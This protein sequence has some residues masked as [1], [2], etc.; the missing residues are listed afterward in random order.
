MNY[1]TN[2]SRIHTFLKCTWNSLQVSVL[3]HKTSL[4]KLKKTEI[5]ESI[6]SDHNGM[7]LEINSRRKTGKSRNK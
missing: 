1:P 7:K 4:N 5:K 2:K 6:S 3:G